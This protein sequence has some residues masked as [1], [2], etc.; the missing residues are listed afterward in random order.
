MPSP[1]YSNPPRLV[2]AMKAPSRKELVKQKREA[3][4]G[5]KSPDPLIASISKLTW[6]M[7]D[8]AEKKLL[9]FCFFVLHF[10]HT[11]I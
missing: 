3:R 6:V 11:H 5:M 8:L 9:T 1:M 4:A 7:L 10:L 2:D